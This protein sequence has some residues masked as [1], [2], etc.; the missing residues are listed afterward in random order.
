M[1]S[2]TSHTYVWCVQSSWR[3]KSAAG[4]GR[5]TGRVAGAADPLPVPA[6]RPCVRSGDKCGSFP[7]LPICSG[8]T[9]VPRTSYSQISRSTSRKT[10]IDCSQISRSIQ[11]PVPVQRKLPKSK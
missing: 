10:K 6:G 5:V 9:R 1:G 4:A 3:Q 11:T 2:S 8:W 7:N